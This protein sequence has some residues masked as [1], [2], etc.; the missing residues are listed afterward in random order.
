M[1]SLSSNAQ[2]D[3]YGFDMHTRDLERLWLMLDEK[4][5]IAT[6]PGVIGADGLAGADGAAGIAATIAVGT[7]TTGA[8]GS[9][10]S[11]VNSGTDSAAV[12]DFTVPQ[13]P[14]GATGPAGPGFTNGSAVGDTKVWNTGTTTWD[15]A[16]AGTALSVFGRSANTPGLPSA[17]VAATSGHVLRY[18]GT[19]L[20]WGSV[21]LAGTNDV[22]GTL[23]ATNG[24]TG[25]ASYAVGDLL[26][27]STTTALSKL[28]AVAV[29]KTLI[30]NGVGVAPSWGTVPIAA[31]GTNATSAVAGS[32][33][34]ASSTTA[35]AWSI[36]PS[37][38]VL[39][40][41]TGGMTVNSATAG[42][43]LTIA[44]STISM[45]KS[46]GSGLTYYFARVSTWTTT[47]GAPAYAGAAGDMHFVY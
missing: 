16:T 45:V 28:S 47:T 17:I 40:T 34:V 18:N 5:G 43:A 44:P 23:P 20:A 35:A 12:F 32:M 14:T 37:L 19:A 10:A 25:N 30:S 21:N 2:F 33:P 39:G 31:G 36:T 1:P 26:Y 29:G 3:Q 41:S 6:T 24:G 8:P 27:A 22:T 13:G 9:S 38:G 15:N 4:S 11:V 46:T 7:T 42:N